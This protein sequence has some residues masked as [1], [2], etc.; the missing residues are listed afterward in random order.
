MNLYVKDTRKPNYI[1]GEIKNDLGE[2]LLTLSSKSF[3]SYHLLSKALKI[4]NNSVEI[5][6]AIIALVGLLTV[7][8]KSERLRN[9]N[10]GATSRIVS[11]RTDHC[12]IRLGED[13][14]SIRSL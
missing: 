11:A 14:I 6:K 12:L 3:L 8:R 2:C 13:S 10:Q 5:V 7:R 1:R 9:T 4:K